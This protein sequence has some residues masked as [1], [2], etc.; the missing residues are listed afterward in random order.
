M[1]HVSNEI[2]YFASK[3][4]KA[5]MEI[6]NAVDAHLVDFITAFN[7]IEGVAT[8]W[9]C[10]GHTGEEKGLG[11]PKDTEKYITRSYIS[12]VTV[13]DNAAIL[14]R[15]SQWLLSSKTFEDQ[16]RRTFSLE[17]RRLK[18][19]GITRDLKDENVYYP[20]FSIEIYY[21]PYKDLDRT[22]YKAALNDLI[23]YLKAGD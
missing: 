5:A 11:A 1:H 2:F 22:Y 8:T 9:C 23:K 6:P 10:S 17:L 7:S 18:L 3:R 13:E 15:I 21:K 20:A 14:E 19:M 12:F 4:A 16:P